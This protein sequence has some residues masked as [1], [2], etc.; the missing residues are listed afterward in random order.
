M[1]VRPRGKGF[2]ADFMLD[3]SRVR[4]TFASFEEAARF[5]AETIAAHLAGRPLPKAGS[6]GRPATQDA[7]TITGLVDRVA[8]KRWAVLKSG[9]RATRDARLYAEFVGTRLPVAEA[10]TDERISDYVDSLTGVVSGRTINR[11][12]SS[13]SALVLAA[14]QG[15]MLSLAPEI[16]WQPNTPGRLRWFSEA[17]VE[18][19]LAT[20]AVIDR[21]YWALF[22]FLVDTGCRLGEAERLQW[23]DIVGGRAEFWDTKNGDHR[24]V[25]LTPRAEAAL[26]YMDQTAPCPAKG[27]F[28]MIQ[29]H[30]L[31][32]IWALLR[33]RL[34]WMDEQCV[35]HTFRHTCA[36]RLVQA[37]IDLYHVG[38]W[39]GHRTQVMTAR[40]SHLA[41]KN[42]DMMAE[43][44]AGDGGG[45]R[46]RTAYGPPGFKPGASTNS[47]TP[48]AAGDNV[49]CALAPAEM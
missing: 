10:L 34:T 36:S 23:G 5:E 8:R 4:H 31:R 26:D 37:G 48:S 30:R 42:F 2:Q 16:P 33:G 15:G 45:G 25:R 22:A 43:V 21:T 18:D 3:G 17:E 27:P 11:R 13:V 12:L 32:T 7:T 38:Q 41:P 1:T 35:V 19:I 14:T 24:A 49:S 20:V 6:V 39:L 9:D 44:L 47:A 28:A 46:T 40:Y 29:R